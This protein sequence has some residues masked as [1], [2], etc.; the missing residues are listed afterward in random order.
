MHERFASATLAETGPGTLSPPAV[1]AAAVSPETR[2]RSRRLQISGALAAK[3]DNKQLLVRIPTSLRPMAH[4]A[5]SFYHS[6]RGNPS[7]LSTT[8][9]S[10]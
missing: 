7:C 2:N 6:G 5:K 10:G 8:F 3:V 1:A 9:L 4:G